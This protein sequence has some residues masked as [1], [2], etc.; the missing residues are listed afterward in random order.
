MTDPKNILITKSD[1]GDSTALMHI[2][3]TYAQKAYVWRA[4]AKKALGSCGGSVVV[5]A[6]EIVASA[7]DEGKF[8]LES[9]S[10]D[11]GRLRVYLE[12]T[13]EEDDGE[14]QDHVEVP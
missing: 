8:G 14:Q 3:A 12:E 7:D 9:E 11:D 4:V 1:P 2:A 5:T 6:E 13:E 10:L